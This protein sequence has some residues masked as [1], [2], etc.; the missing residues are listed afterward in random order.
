MAVIRLRA[1]QSCH[2][3]GS[4]TDLPHADHHDCLDAIGRE[5]LLLLERTRE[6]TA[7]RRR[8]VEQQVMEIDERRARIAHKLKP[9]RRKRK[10]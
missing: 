10:R 8:L 2:R 4:S 9:V 7:R 6:L 5:V 3:C 1:N